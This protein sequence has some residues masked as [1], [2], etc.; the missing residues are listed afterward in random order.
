MSDSEFHCLSNSRMK[1]VHI[2]LGTA[3]PE[4]MNGVDRV[5]YYLANEMSGAGYNVEV[6]AL[7][8]GEPRN[9]P[10]SFKL[11]SFPVKRYR[12]CLVGRLNEALSALYGN[13][14]V[15][16]HSVFIPEFYAI[17]RVLID[18]HIPWVLTPHCG[19]SEQSL[20][21]NR[22]VKWAYMY[23][24]ERVIIRKAQG[25][26]ALGSI[27]FEQL[28]TWHNTIRVIPN[29]Q[30]RQL[31]GYI[32]TAEVVGGPCIFAFCGR[33]S[34][35]QKGLDLLIAGFSIYVKAG[36]QGQL[37]IVGDGPDRK[38][39]EESAIEFGLKE[40]IRFWGPQFGSEKLKLLSRSHVFVH[41]SR[42]EGLPMAVL[43]AASI[44]LPLLISVETNMS[45]YVSK[46]EAGFVVAP[47]DPP[48]IAKGFLRCA[49]AAEGG[50]LV[51]WGKNSLSMVS[52]E[53][54]WSVIAGRVVAEL[55]S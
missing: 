24:F 28:K 27:E 7:G 1:I 34:A 5:V 41:T 33:L 9:F 26:H 51:R 2:V 18:K 46:H 12:F 19:Y 44:G 55:Y 10:R 45:E 32:R 40:K 50:E 17:T 15:H 49:K 39:L 23:L 25:I 37:W 30:T 4:A 21:R 20:G 13:V 8:D 47:N 52:T 36:G 42:W 22:L 35:E 53:F 48:T 43:E 11:L 16:F 6:W 31:E 3:D 14:I 29:G 38:D 54:D